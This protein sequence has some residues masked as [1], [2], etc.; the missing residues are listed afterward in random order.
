MP[1]R[2]RNKQIGPGRAHRKGIS[3]LELFEMFPSDAA[4]EA[5]FEA[6]RWPD[7]VRTCPDCGSDRTGVSAHRTMPYRCQECRAFFSVRKGTA[8][9]GSKLGFR[10]WAIGIYMMSTSLK[11]TSSMKMNRELGI[12]QKTAWHLQQRIREGFLGNTGVRLDGPVEID[13]TY[14]G[15]KEKNKHAGKK[16]RSGRGTVGKAV[17]AGVKDRKTKEVRAEVVP[18]TDGDTLQGF[19]ADHVA[20]GASE[21]HRRG[22]CLS[23]SQQPRHLPALGRPMGRRTG[24]HQRLGVLLGHAQAWLPWN[25]PSHVRQAPAPLRRRVRR[26]AQHPRQGHPGENV[27]AGERVGWEAAALPGSHHMSKPRSSRGSGH[28]EKPIIK[29]PASAEEIGERIFANAKPPDPSKRRHGRSTGGR[30]A[31]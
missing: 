2:K 10:K 26:P 3:I 28:P 20:S 25:L 15:G 24:P 14:V 18:A 31:G 1:K 7:G 17:V 4:T 13:E 30:K 8:M 9:E 12:T 19:V 21:V 29:L 27:S 16:L 23:G 22:Q 6:Q 11:G 5:W